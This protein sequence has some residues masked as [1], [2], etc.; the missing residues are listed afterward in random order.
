LDLTISTRGRVFLRGRGIDAEVEGTIGLGGNLR[1]PQVRGGFEL[2][3]GTFTVAG[4]TLDFTSGKVTFDGMSI[5][6][7]IDPALD[8]AAQTISGGITATLA[9]TGYASA[10]RIELSSVPQLP[11]DEILARIFFRRSTT[12][13]TPVQLVQ[14]AQ[15]ALSLASGDTRFDP[16]RS[17]ERGLGLSRLT[18]GS[19]EAAGQATPETTIE[20]GTYVLRNVYVG[21]RQSLGSGTQAEV[22]INLTDKLK[23]LGTVNTGANANVTQGSKQRETGSSIGLSYEF[24][25]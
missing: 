9:V 22:Q 8:L 12:Q 20:A 3:R 2:R 16:L 11:Q 24:E 7:R 6:N 14:L 15:T 4:Q 25:Y 18:I 23:L 10:P 13:L 1:T 21:A 17:L 19:R 5:Q